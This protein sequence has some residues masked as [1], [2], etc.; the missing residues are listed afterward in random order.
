M[1]A[2]VEGVL[3]DSRIKRAFR[4]ISEHEPEIEAD[5][6]RLSLV[7]AGPFQ[8]HERARVFSD[9][10]KKTRFHP[11]TDSMGNVVIGYEYIGADPVVMA[12]HLDTV[13]PQTMPLQLRRK[14][15]TLFLPGISDNGA[16]IVALLWTLRAAKDAG[17][18][19]RRSVIGVGTVGEEGAGNLRGV[20]FLFDSPPWSGRNCEFIAIDGGG[21]NRIT[22]QALGSRRFRVVM[23]GPGGHSWADFGRPNPIQAVAM[24]IHTFS[25]AGMSR[26]AGNAF[27][28]G[29][30]HGGISVNAIPSEVSTEVDLRS[31]TAGDLDEM[32][33][34][35]RRIV[36]ESARTTGVAFQIEKTGDRPSGAT[37]AHLPIVQVALEASRAFGVEA[38]LDIGST[39]ANIPISIGVPAIGIG[40]GGSSGN[41]HTP[42]EWFDPTQRHLGIQ[43]LLTIVATLAGLA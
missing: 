36:A 17:I 43:R 28:F 40:G 11:S 23:Q 10:L 27:N 26:R 39:D 16:G 22:H 8:E 24:A 9:E 13:F 34:R 31:V 1:R 19:F 5:Q 38:Q 29:V 7:P 15:N 42:E 41:I 21:L 30:I 37:S 25:G 6:I 35:L 32:D 4:F 18:R 14:A 2:S 3:A 20:R 12:A 33:S